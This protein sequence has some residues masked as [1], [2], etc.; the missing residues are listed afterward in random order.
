SF[1]GVGYLFSYVPVAAHDP[2]ILSP[3]DIVKYKAFNL[4]NYGL[5]KHALIGDCVLHAGMVLND[6]RNNWEVEQGPYASM[7]EVLSFLARRELAVPTAFYDFG[8]PG[9]SFQI[10]LLFLYQALKLHN[11][12]SV[13][14]SNFYGHPEVYESA[15][16]GDILE[17]VY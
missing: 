10:Q 11:I 15:K 4:N 16:P 8:V 3:S 1:L 14:L 12:K 9:S 6:Y 2:T 13:M 17:A 5:E 7:G